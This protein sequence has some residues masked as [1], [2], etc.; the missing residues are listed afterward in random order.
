MC[1]CAC[2]LVPSRVDVFVFVCACLCFCLRPLRTADSDPAAAGL[3]QRLAE[4]EARYAARA[5]VCV[6]GRVVVCSFVRLFFVAAFR[7]V[8]VCLLGGRASTS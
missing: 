1:L 4:A 3:K 2:V 5:C 6:G 7:L 8:C